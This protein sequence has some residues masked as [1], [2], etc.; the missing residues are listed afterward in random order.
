[1]RMALEGVLVLGLFLMLRRLGQ[2]AVGKPLHGSGLKITSHA[3]FRLEDQISCC[4]NCCLLQVIPGIA[5]C[6]V[7][8]AMYFASESS[9]MD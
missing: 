7:D 1:M 9:I 3:R 8:A 6:R 2:Q 5:A 4:C